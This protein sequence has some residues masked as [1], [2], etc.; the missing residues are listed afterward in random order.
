MTNRVDLENRLWKAQQGLCSICRERLLRDERFRDDSGWSL[1]H[2]FPRAH[3]EL[4]NKGNVL[5]AHKLCNR[6]KSDRDPTGCEVVLLHMV[7]ARLGHQ[8]ARPYKRERPSS[9][10]RDAWKRYVEAQVAAVGS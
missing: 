5:L 6:V 3:Y 2:V 9:T 1:D 8:L 4:G 7:N 10:I